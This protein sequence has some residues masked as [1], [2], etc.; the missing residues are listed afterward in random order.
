MQFFPPSQAHL[1]SADV[2]DIIALK[3]TFPTSFDTTGN[4]P[5]EYT[6]CVDPSRPPVQHAHRKYQ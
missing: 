6:L 4:M 2:R 3:H 5:G 1:T